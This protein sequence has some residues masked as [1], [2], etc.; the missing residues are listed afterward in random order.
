MLFD[1]ELSSFGK[2]SLSQ[3]DDSMLYIFERINLILFFN[4]NHNDCYLT[5]RANLDS[6]NNHARE[7]LFRLQFFIF[8][9]QKNKKKEKKK[10]KELLMH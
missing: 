6:F 9:S 8:T 1:N 3:L 10:T 7:F 5:R 2:I 4:D